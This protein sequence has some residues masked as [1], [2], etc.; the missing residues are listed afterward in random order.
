MKI[1]LRAIAVLCVL[2]GCFL[3]YAVI[4]AV[5]SEG[6]ARPA[7]AVLYVVI[8]IALGFLAAWLWRRPGRAATPAA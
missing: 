5:G 1:L 7:V 6:G 3:V 4:H 2:L 8:A